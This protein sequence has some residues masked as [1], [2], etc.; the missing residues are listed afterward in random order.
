MA[1]KELIDEV[2]NESDKK[3][4]VKFIVNE[5]LPEAKNTFTPEEYQEIKIYAEKKLGI[6]LPD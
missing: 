5:V 3:D 6:K 4:A 2:I 1:L